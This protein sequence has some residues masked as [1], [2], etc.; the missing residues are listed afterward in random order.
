MLFI[1]TCVLG[2]VT[3]LEETPRDTAYNTKRYP[4]SLAADEGLHS[5]GSGALW[6]FQPLFCLAQPW[7]HRPGSR[8]GS[9]VRVNFNRAAS[10]P[11]QPLAPQA[12]PECLAGQLSS[13]ALALG[14]ARPRGPR[15]SP[16]RLHPPS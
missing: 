3:L 15:F 7:H 5:W 1:L 10:P 11:I 2:Y 8:E 6:H 16:S 4:P 13:D 14:S 12:S 9:G